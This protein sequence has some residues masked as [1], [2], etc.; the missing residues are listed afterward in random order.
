MTRKAS[1]RRYWLSMILLAL[2]CASTSIPASPAM[3]GDNGNLSAPEQPSSST[4][5]DLHRLIDAHQLTELRTTYNSN[6]GASLLFQ[7]DK[8]SY[9]VALFHGK[10]FWRVI[11][12]DSYEDAES[13]YRAFATQ[14]QQLAQVDIDAMRLQAGKAYAEHMVAVNQQHLQH[15]QQDV[16]Y[17]QQQA[18]QVATQQQQAQQQ[19]V[20]LSA[21]LR[22]TSNQLETVK[23]QIRALEEQQTNPTLALPPPTQPAAAAAATEP[24]AASS[25]PASSSL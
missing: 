2:T 8:L 13:L 14:T 22:S 16:A 9:Y 18:R 10:E 19:A 15:L 25:A 4:V 12:T 3:P 23:Q 6:Y 24:A 21:E 5:A 11:Q 1:P 7:S 20:S 17:Q